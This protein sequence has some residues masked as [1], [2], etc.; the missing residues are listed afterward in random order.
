MKKLLTILT[1]SLT[2]LST[3]LI[4]SRIMASTIHPTGSQY[5]MVCHTSDSIY[6][7]SDNTYHTTIVDEDGEA[8]T[9]LTTDKLLNNTW[10][11]VIFNDQGT[12]DKKDDVIINFNLLQDNM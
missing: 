2:L 5:S 6:N 12:P 9:A 11:D 4:P 3:S 7:A 10:L 8:F 1:L